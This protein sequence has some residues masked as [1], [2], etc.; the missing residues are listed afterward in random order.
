[1]ISYIHS[2]IMKR[3]LEIAGASDSGMS[4]EFMVLQNGVMTDDQKQGL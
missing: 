3:A 2:H 1:M 4:Y